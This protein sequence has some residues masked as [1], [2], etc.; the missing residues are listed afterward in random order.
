MDPFQKARR[1]R[2]IWPITQQLTK[3]SVR[4]IQ[5]LMQQV[6]MVTLAPRLILHLNLLPLRSRHRPSV[7]TVAILLLSQGPC[8]ATTFCTLFSFNFFI[9]TLL[10]NAFKMLV[11]YCIFSIITEMAKPRI[12]TMYVKKKSPKRYY[13]KIKIRRWI[14][15]R[16]KILILKI[17]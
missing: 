8:L 9:S 15:N 12:A 14:T 7:V 10:S 2:R 1:P 4:Q 16:K 13:L 17:P 6:P 5:Q 11:E 3:P